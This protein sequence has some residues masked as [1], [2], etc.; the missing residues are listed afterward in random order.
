MGSLTGDSCTTCTTTLE[1]TNSWTIYSRMRAKK[2]RMC[3]VLS[4][5][6]KCEIVSFA[7]RNNI[8]NPVCEIEGNVL[9]VSGTA[10]V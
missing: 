3:S 6:T 4:H 9:T 1:I 5:P 8:D 7:Q 10:T 2:L